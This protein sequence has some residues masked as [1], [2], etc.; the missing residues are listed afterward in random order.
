MSGTDDVFDDDDYG[1]VRWWDDLEITGK[2]EASREKQRQEHQERLTKLYDYCI[3][4]VESERLGETKLYPL[5]DSERQVY[6]LDQRINDRGIL[7][8]IETVK[9]ALG[10]VDKAA[11]RLQERIAKLTGGWV[12]T[13]N[14]RD[15]LIK[16]FA[17][18]GCHFTSLDKQGITN[19]LKRTDLPP[20]VREVLEI[21]QI[22]AKSS[23][24]KLEAIMAMADDKGRIHGNLLYHG[25]STG[26]FAGKGVQLQNLP[27][28]ELLDN[29][30]EA[31]PFIRRDNIDEIEMCFGPT[32]TVVSDIIRSLFMA[33]E[34]KVLYAADFAAIEAR[35]LAWIAGQD[36]LVKQF[37]NGDD[38]YLSFAGRVYGKTL[39]KKEH[40]K[41]RQLGK[42]CVAEGTLVYTDYGL[43]PI[44]QVTFDMRVWD[45]EEWVNH[46]GVLSNGT[47][48]VLPL[49]GVWLTPDHRVLSGTR[50]RE[51]QFLAHDESGLSLALGTGAGS[52]P[53]LATC[54]ENAAVFPP[55]WSSAIAAKTNTELTT[56]VFAI[57]PALDARCARTLK[58]VLLGS[59]FGG[60]RTFAQTTNTAKDSSTESRR[61]FNDAR[62]Q[63]IRDTILTAGVGSEFTARGS[64]IGANFSGICSLWMGG[65]F[66]NLNWIASTIT[67]DMCRGICD[68]SPE[69]K[70]SII[71]EVSGH[72][73]AKSKNLK[74]VYDLMNA[75]PRNRYT[76]FTNSGPLVVH[77]CILGL[78]FGMGPPKFEMTIAKDQMILPEG[79]AQRIVKLYRDTYAQIPKFWYGLERA[80]LKAVGNPNLVVTYRGLRL[81]MRDGNLRLQLPSGRVLNYP[82]AK[83]VDARTP[84]GEVKRAV[85]ISA[86]NAMTRKWERTTVSPGTF[87]ENVVQAIA[88]D[89]MVAAMFRLEEANYPVI[90][91][92]HDEVISEVD[93]SYGSVAEYESLVAATPDWAAGLPVKAEGWSGKRYRK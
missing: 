8:D 60:M 87:V 61:V 14:Q 34:G 5:S 46:L 30:E 42:A 58:V 3:K 22:G 66:Q 25:A 41:E 54:A 50:W 73:S 52:L 2:T 1:Q 82:Q 26:R 55:L 47:Q 72:Y 70:T 85:E 7:A 62:T 28:P 17:A 81:R 39:N 78:G 24:K 68:L 36:D 71:G 45:G 77:N 11:G 91:T 57:S 63:M 48:N 6:L 83:V 56:T 74:P 38:I 64:K 59:C 4:D 75:G 13:L 16:W 84:W 21:R 10:L 53:S 9:C 65:M 80:A 20:L 37:A 49:C 31:I 35:V 23:T 19:A 89:L 44:E 27:R 69:K 92:V 93:E 18:Q 43:V 76:I 86:V 88:R 15:R 67:L 90:L 29:P 32:Q 51:A 40:P 33:E 79:E 12:T